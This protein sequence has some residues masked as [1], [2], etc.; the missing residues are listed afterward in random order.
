MESRQTNPLT[1]TLDI[2]GNFGL[3]VPESSGLPE[4]EYPAGCTIICRQVHPLDPEDGE[5]VAFRF[6]DGWRVGSL[7]RPYGQGPTLDGK[8]FDDDAVQPHWAGVVLG[9]FIPRVRAE[10]AE[11]A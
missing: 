2:A 10:A 7:R 8:A 4:S 9:V 3:G 1:I 11:T 6:P 5:V